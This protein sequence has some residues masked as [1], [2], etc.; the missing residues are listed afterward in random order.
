MEKVLSGSHVLVEDKDNFDVMYL[1]S[2]A[3]D[4]RCRFAKKK[5]H[6]SKAPV[7]IQT[8]GWLFNKKC[9]K[10]V[11]E[12]V[13]LKLM[14]LH[15]TGLLNVPRSSKDEIGIFSSKMIEEDC[16]K[17]STSK[18]QMCKDEKEFVDP[19]SVFQLKNAFLGLFVGHALAIVAFVSEIIF[20]KMLKMNLFS[21]RS[22]HSLW[23]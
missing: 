15:S 9:P 20:D 21:A 11:Q 23:P 22:K 3:Q 19:L 17:V 8:S 13:N 14:R 18:E 2:L 7:A 6:L 1:D 10:N 5:F 12:I 16:P 4:V